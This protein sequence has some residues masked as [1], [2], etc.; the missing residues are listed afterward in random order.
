MMDIMMMALMSGKERGLYCR[1]GRHYL[2]RLIP[3]LHG[4]EVVDLMGVVF[5]LYRP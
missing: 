5:G 1:C 3:A 4:M 2:S